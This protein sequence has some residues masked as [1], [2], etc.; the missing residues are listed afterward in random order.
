MAKTPKSTEPY[1]KQET[2]RR[3]TEDTMQAA[4]KDITERLQR[5]ERKEVQHATKVKVLQDMYQK[6]RN[7]MNPRQAAAT[8]HAAGNQAL[9][10]KELPVMKDQIAKMID[11]INTPKQ[12]TL[13]QM[14]IERGC[15]ISRTDEQLGMGN[16]NK[17]PDNERRLK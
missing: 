3:M 9:D 13:L 6:E 10:R 8:G 5:M 16:L 2:S 12:R 11:V 15:N 1:S 7:S 17:K 4:W 14:K